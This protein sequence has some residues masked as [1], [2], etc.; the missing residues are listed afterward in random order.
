MNISSGQEDLLLE[1]FGT[2]I[3]V[4]GLWCGCDN[5]KVFGELGKG[6]SFLLH[7]SHFVHRPAFLLCHINL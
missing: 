3:R 1:L 7:R 6:T 2:N 5:L 4:C